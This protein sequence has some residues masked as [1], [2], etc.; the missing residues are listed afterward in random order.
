MYL[1]IFYLLR[2]L[3]HLEVLDVKILIVKILGK[4][5]IH[6]SWLWPTW[7]FDKSKFRLTSGVFGNKLPYF[8]VDF[9]LF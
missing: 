1:N 6:K 7:N 9:I 8:A 5:A 2:F 3:N 4:N